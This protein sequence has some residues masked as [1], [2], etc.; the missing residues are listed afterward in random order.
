MN[1]MARTRMAAG[2]AL[3]T[4]SA[5]GII[6]G[7]IFGW[8]GAPRPWGLLLGLVLGL[9]AGLGATLAVTGMIGF[10]RGG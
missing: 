4:V 7:A 10:R 6:L 1:T 3:A 5:T 9:M 8:F 2:S